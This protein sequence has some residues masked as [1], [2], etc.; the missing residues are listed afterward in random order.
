LSSANAPLTNQR[1]SQRVVLAVRIVVSGTP[2]IGSPFAEDTV[3]V[4]VNAHGAMIRLREPVQ[5]EQML[6]VRNAATGEELPC[7]VIDVSVGSNGQPEV[8]V[9]FTELNP[10]FWRVSFPPADWN[11]RSPEARRFSLPPSG[12]PKPAPTPLA[13]RKK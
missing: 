11:P 10:H 5:K 2:D 12:T 9:E 4:V 1:R 3:T 8:G 7:K 6:R 13:N